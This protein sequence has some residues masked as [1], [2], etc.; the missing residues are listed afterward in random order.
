MLK[1][2]FEPFQIEISLKCVV[3]PLASL[4]LNSPFLD[5]S[6][7]CQLLDYRYL[8]SKKLPFGH[9]SSK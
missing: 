3:I 7:I 4:S 6:H 5:D 2:S 8:K 9:F 1:L